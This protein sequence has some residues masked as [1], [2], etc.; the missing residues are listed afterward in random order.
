MVRLKKKKKEGRR[1]WERN[2]KTTRQKKKKKKNRKV[3]ETA[4]GLINEPGSRVLERISASSK[5]TQEDSGL[6][7]LKNNEKKKEKGRDADKEINKRSR[8]TFITHVFEVR[9]D[10]E[11]QKKKKQRGEGR[12]NGKGISLLAP[13]KAER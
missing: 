8:T 9:L 3:R 7:H 4:S 2:T 11:N 1:K 6:F 5:E 12:K 13:Q 10:N